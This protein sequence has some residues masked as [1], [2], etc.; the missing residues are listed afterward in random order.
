[1]VLKRTEVLET[2]YFKWNFVMNINY[3]SNNN[4][5]EATITITFS[6]KQT[7]MEHYVNINLI[8]PS[9]NVESKI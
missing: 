1:M 9:L 7:I 5:W 8:S 4:I 6:C 2:F 3:D